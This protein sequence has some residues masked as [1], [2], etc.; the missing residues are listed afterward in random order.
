MNLVHELDVEYYCNTTSY[1]TTCNSGDFSWTIKIDINK[2]ALL[3]SVASLTLLQNSEIGEKA[4]LQEPPKMMHIPNN[5][6]M[7]TTTT[8]HLLPQAL[9]EG[10]RAA[11]VLMHNDLLSTAVLCGAGCAVELNKDAC[12]VQYQ[13]K[14]VL[15][16]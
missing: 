7:N 10:G 2:T 15:Q 4:M 5:A 8:L 13:G 11:H 14:V 3:D 6:T 1:S 16:G 12:L 9:P